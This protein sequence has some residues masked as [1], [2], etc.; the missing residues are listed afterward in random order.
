MNKIAVIHWGF[1]L[2]QQPSTQIIIP[3]LSEMDHK[4]THVSGKNIMIYYKKQ[5]LNIQAV[6]KQAQ[7]LAN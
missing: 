4:P 6:Q 1:N 5:S 7:Q 2:L 3:A